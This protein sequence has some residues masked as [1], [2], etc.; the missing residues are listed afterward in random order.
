MVNSMQLAYLPNRRRDFMI[1]EDD[2][3][4]SEFSTEGKGENS[5]EDS[6]KEEKKNKKHGMLN[7]FKLRVMFLGQCHKLCFS[8]DI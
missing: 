5:I 7:W 8:V 4:D 6:S 2:S 3:H 1:E